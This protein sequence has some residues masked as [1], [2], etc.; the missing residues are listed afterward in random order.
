MKTLIALSI[1][2]SLNTFAKRKDLKPSEKIQLIKVLEENEK[3][4][5]AFFDYSQEKVIKEA[6]A[7]EAV[8]DKVGDK[9]LSTVMAKVKN[10]LKKISKNSSREENNEAYALVSANLVYIVNTYELGDKYNSY[11]CPMVKK[12]WIQNSKKMKRV[13]NPYAPGMPHCGQRDSD[14]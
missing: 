12:K 14:Y 9:E 11:S 13:H 7:L 8:V 2:F 4:H 10:G 6:R 5:A 1:L 3:L